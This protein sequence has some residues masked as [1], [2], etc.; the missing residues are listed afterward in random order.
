MKTLAL[1]LLLIGCASVTPDDRAKVYL[2][3][4]HEWTLQC[5]AYQFDRS[6][7]LVEEVPDMAK[8]CK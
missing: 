2:I 4:A 6:V 7:G 3:R 5:K 1:S 8:A